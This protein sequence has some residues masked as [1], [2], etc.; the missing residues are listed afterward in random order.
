[1]TRNFWSK[2][3][4]STSREWAHVSVT[5]AL[6]ATVACG[7]DSNKEPAPIPIHGGEKLAWDQPAASLQDLRALTFTLY[8]D[9]GVSSLTNPSCADQPGAAGFSCSGGL[10]VMSP[11]RHVLELTSVLNG[12]ESPRSSRLIVSLSST[13]AVSSPLSDSKRLNT[14]P[15]A[16]IGGA[17]ACQQVRVVAAGLASPTMLVASRNDKVF[18]V[19]DEKQIRVIADDVLSRE[20]AMVAAPGSRIVGLAVENRDTATPSVFVAWTEAKQPNQTVVNV[21]RYREVQGLLGEGA[22]IVTG[23]PLP[24]GAF[25][26]LAVGDDGLLYMA[27][28]APTGGPEGTILRFTLDGFTPPGSPQSSPLFAPGSVR[29]TTLAN[30]SPTAIWSAGRRQDSSAE[31]ATIDLTVPSPA[32]RSLQ[33]SDSTVGP[34]GRVPLR[35]FVSSSPDPVISPTSSSHVLVVTDGHLY[36]GDRSGGEYLVLNQVEFDPEPTVLGVVQTATG[37]IYVSVVP[38]GRQAGAIWRLRQQ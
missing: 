25:T 6:I 37:A 2:R 31:I 16:C 30:G 9:G 11:G 19:D 4:A 32:P 26:P 5:C 24:E 18:F 1:M 23:L 8:L 13:A 10:P 14:L 36:F 20:P 38:D 21:T 17:D 29:P 7:G 22:Q 28:P 34:D 33:M 12:A 3:I 35:Q 27:V 15:T